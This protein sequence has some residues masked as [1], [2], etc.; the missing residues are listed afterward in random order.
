MCVHSYIYLYYYN[1]HKIFYE[2]CCV[3][4]FDAL[5]WRCIRMA[6]KHTSESNLGGFFSKDI[7]FIR[8]EISCVHSVHRITQ[9]TVCNNKFFVGSHS[10][11]PIGIKCVQQIRKQ[12]TRTNT[13]TYIFTNNLIILFLKWVEICVLCVDVGFLFF[14]FIFWSTHTQFSFFLQRHFMHYKYRETAFQLIHA[15][16]H[17]CCWDNKRVA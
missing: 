17:L 15:H 7:Q 16:T 3:C 4:A 10:T 9:Q 11:T 14:I 13:N 2:I 1:A 6:L 5:F 8:R 12:Q